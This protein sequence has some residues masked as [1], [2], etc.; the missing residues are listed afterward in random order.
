MVQFVFTPWRDRHE[1]LTARDHFY[2][3]DQDD[4]GRRRELQHGAVARVSMWMQRGNCPHLV[5]STALLTAAVLCDTERMSSGGSSTYAV[6]AAYSTAFSRFVTGLLDM[7]Q[8]K[9]R[10]MSMFSVAKTIGLPATFVELRH[11]ATHEQLPSLA[12]LRSAA[13]KALAWI[14]DYY[15][16]HL[17]A[18]QGAEESRAD[19]CR[20]AVVEYLDSS[21]A[22][23]P[24]TKAE[25]LRVLLARWGKTRVLRAAIEISE[26][27]KKVRVL[28]GSVQLSR[29]L[30]QS[31]D[32]SVAGS[33]ASSAAHGVEGA[34]TEYE[35]VREELAARESSG[36]KGDAGGGETAA[37]AS[38]GSENE[39]GWSSYEQWE[40]KPIGVV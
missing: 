39:I 4:A 20:D 22:T 26:T 5:E 15:W 9:Q 31:A 6:R 24:T 16:Q 28:L 19:P 8:D 21:A 25:G 37:E 18:D 12:R 17:T 33:G 13:E 23:D 38:S 7:Q 27:T 14:W 3:D 40:P 34:R 30:L 11:Q 32:S 35:K 36:S 2:P 10:K 29:E 1:L